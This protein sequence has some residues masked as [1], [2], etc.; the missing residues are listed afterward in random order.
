MNK[1]LILNKLKQLKPILKEKFNIEKIA[2]FGS[3]ATE[4]N[5]E[6]SDIDLLIEYKEG[7]KLNYFEEENLRNLLEQELG[8]EK[9]DLVNRK[10]INPVI[11]FFAQKS[12]I[13]V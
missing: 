1:E 13:Y 10:F 12:L 7:D 5:T 8:T 9:I 6:N 2:L 4:K 11:H 3:F